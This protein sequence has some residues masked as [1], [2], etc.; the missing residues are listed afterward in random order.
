MV[1]FNDPAV[2]AAD[3]V[4][5]AKLWHTVGGLY[6]W[7]FF[8]TLEYEWKVF[9]GRLPY[10]WTIWVYSFARVSVLVSVI[11]RFFLLDNTTPINCQVALTTTLVLSSLSN[12]ASSLLIVLRIIAIWNKNKVVMAAAISIWC[13]NI[14]FLIKSPVEIRAVWLNTQ[15]TC[16]GDTR[17]N[18]PPGLVSMLITDISLLLIMLV[19]LFRLRRHGS[20]FGLNQVLWRQG[21]LWLLLATVADVPPVVFVLLNLNAP[22]NVM[23]IMPTWVTM[24]IAATRMHRLLVDFAF[25]ST[26][27][28]IE[29]MTPQSSNPPVQNTERP[30][31]PANPL[32]RMEVAVHVVSEQDRASYEGDGVSSFHTGEQTCG[33][34]SS[35]DVEE[36]DEYIVP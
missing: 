32:D 27:I 5:M 4:E 25:R 26:E 6:I 9:R 21:V 31:I 29:H 20:A 11:L 28:F 7:E 15:L 19:G 24:A 13:I 18:N 34:S 16:V 3:S 14:G 30:P 17:R 35:D 22:L 1:N 33:G 23:F 2:I 10:R 36:R 12:T 8:T